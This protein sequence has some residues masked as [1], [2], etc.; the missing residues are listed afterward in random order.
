MGLIN[1]RFDNSISK[2]YSEEFYKKFSRKYEVIYDDRE[3]RAG[4][5]FNNMDLIGVPLQVIIGEKNLLNSNIEVK[6]R[7]TGK[8]ELISLDKIESYLEKYCEH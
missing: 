1:I 6:H 8:L 5:K 3:V 7:N 4:E 2:D